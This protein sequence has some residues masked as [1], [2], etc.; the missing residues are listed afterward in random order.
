MQE[1]VFDAIHSAMQ[2]KCARIIG[3]NGVDTSGKTEFARSFS[4]YLSARGIENQVVHIDDFHNPRA[5]RKNYYEDAFDLQTVAQKVLQPFRNNGE[6]DASHLCLDLDSDTYKNPRRYQLSKRGILIVEGTLLFRAPLRDYF[7]LK[8]FLK[9]EFDEMLRRAEL[10]DVPKY[11]AKIL[12]SYCSRYIPAQKRYFADCNPETQ[13]D[14]L[15]DN[16]DWE[17][18]ILL[19][20]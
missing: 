1:Q 6:L 9:I 2:R 4:G 12:E 16:S 10:R 5:M 13:N 17:H 19:K 7:V 14:I 11:G 3:I 18:P 8:V 15:I 20:H